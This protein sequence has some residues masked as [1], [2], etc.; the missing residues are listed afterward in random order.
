VILDVIATYPDAVLALMLM[1]G[2]AIFAGSQIAGSVGFVN[3]IRTITASAV[4]HVI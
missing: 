3:S 4:S 1:D 2:C